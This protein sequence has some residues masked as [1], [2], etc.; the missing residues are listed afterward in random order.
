MG[1]RL[2]WHLQQLQQKF[3]QYVVE[4]RGKGLISGIKITPPIRDFVDRLRCHN[5]L[6]VAAGD[7]VL[8]LLPP[9]IVTEADI[10]EAMDKIAEA[11]TELDQETGETSGV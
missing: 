1:R 10:E 2:S 11:F 5:L 6:A 8:R 7:N 4:L 3:P 9:L